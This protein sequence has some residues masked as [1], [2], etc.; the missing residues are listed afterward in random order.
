MK[1]LIT[2]LFESPN[3]PWREC[4]ALDKGGGALVTLLLSIEPLHALHHFTSLTCMVM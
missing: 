3:L 4:V 2:I 1:S